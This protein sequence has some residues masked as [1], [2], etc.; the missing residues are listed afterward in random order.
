MGSTM[1]AR[2]RSIGSITF[3]ITN[4]VF[5]LVV[6]FVTL[7]PMYYIAIISISNGREVLAERVNFWPRGI[8]IEAYR[9]VLRDASI[10]RAL[11]N[12][13][14]YTA[15]GTAIN[16]SFTAMCAFPLSRR[17]FSGRKVLT[18]FVTVTMFFG[19]GL[20]PLYLVV[21]RIGLINSM[22]AVVLVPA[23]NTWYMFIMRTYFQGLPDALQESA[24]I[25]GAN[26]IHI[27]IRII[28]P[29]AKP[30]MATLLLFYAVY[31]WN[32]FFN[33]MIFLN[34][35]KKFPIQI[36]LRNVVVAGRMDA[37]NEIGAGI[38]YM[39]IEQTIK[40]AVIM[41]STLPILIVYPF[42]QKYFVK[43]VMIG[44]IKG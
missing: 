12:T 30:I 35:K 11:A 16:L 1:K 38:E 29:L 25:D 18:I 9:L 23:I 32:S 21:M 36:I 19:G 26:D 20:I 31:H 22:W 41:V 43:G 5:M 4:I 6:V 34:E 10:V 14:L 8:N 7:Y 39:V 28:I 42:L 33:A 3:D 17:D 44:A 40:Y 15:V 13:V 2:Y 37:T 24:I 27:L